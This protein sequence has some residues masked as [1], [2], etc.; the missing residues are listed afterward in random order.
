MIIENP[1]NLDYKEAKMGRRVM[2][3]GAQISE[4]WKRFADDDTVDRLILIAQSIE[5]NGFREALMQHPAYRSGKIH[6]LIYETT[7]PELFRVVTDIVF[8]WRDITPPDARI[9]EIYHL[10]LQREYEDPVERI[11]VAYIG[12]KN[13]LEI[14][15]LYRSKVFI[16]HNQSYEE[17]REEEMV[18][19]SKM[20]IEAYRQKHTLEVRLF[21]GHQSFARWLSMG[22]F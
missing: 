22:L 16:E 21:S 3:V 15:K 6:L 8:R 19:V 14:A 1:A 9:D 11:D 12:M 18:V 4:M 7:E 10:M 20:L 2:I 5:T 17:E 13:M